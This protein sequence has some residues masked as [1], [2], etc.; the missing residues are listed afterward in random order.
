MRRQELMVLVVSLLM[1][2]CLVLP[3]EAAL[4]S[5]EV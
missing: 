3:A 5:P 4:A 2:F 1:V